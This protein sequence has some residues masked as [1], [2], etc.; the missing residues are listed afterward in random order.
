MSTFNIT[1][2]TSSWTKLVDAND[3]DFFI[4]WDAAKTV[5][6]ASTEFDIA[7][8]GKGHRF[9]REK[10]VTREDVGAGYVWGK[11]ATLGS[12]TS[13]KV[14]VSK[15]TSVAGATGGFD[16]V[17]GVHKVAMMVWNPSTLAWER[18]TGSGSSG[19]GSSGE[20]ATL[21]KRIDPGTN[22]IYVGTAT[23]GTSES[24]IGWTVQ[25]I[26]LNNEGAAV[27]IK[28]GTGAWDNRASLSFQ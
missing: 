5:E 28:I 25:K 10:K 14:T 23:L 19:G 17:E 3:T 22:T 6:I 21:T 13:F 9:T 26:E 4:T 1:V 24:S 20:P 2:D 7:P 8:V 16:T 11:L 15:T 27:S 12:G 18:S